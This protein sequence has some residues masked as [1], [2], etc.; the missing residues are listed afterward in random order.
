MNHINQP[1]HCAYGCNIKIGNNFYLLE[2][3]R[4]TLSSQLTY[5]LEP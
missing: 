1:F 2:V 4:F 5:W 3:R